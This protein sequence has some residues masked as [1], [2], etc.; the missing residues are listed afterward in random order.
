MTTNDITDQE[1]LQMG[2]SILLLGMKR[3]ISLLQSQADT[4]ELQLTAPPAA[5]QNGDVP[6]RPAMQRT[7]ALIE[8]AEKPTVREMRK[9]RRTNTTGMK[10]Y[11]AQFT[12]EERSREM[13][14]RG[15][16]AKRRRKA[17]AR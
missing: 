16:I 3:V 8:E 11:W 1:C 17:A 6:I 14:R 13:E 10:A 7:M 5:P 15:R 2:R 9:K 4:L 12:P